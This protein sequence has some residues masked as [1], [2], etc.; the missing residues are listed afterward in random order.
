MELWNIECGDDHWDGASSR[1]VAHRDKKKLNP[2]EWLFRLV[3]F[4]PSTRWCAGFVQLRAMSV[5]GTVCIVPMTAE[6]MPKG[7]AGQKKGS[8]L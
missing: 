8:G 3:T 5:G 1:L 4:E 7:R 2:S 6:D